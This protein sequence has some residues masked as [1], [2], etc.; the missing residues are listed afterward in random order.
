MTDANNHNELTAEALGRYLMEIVLQEIRALPDVWEKLSEN[1]QADVIDRVRESVREAV[2]G[3]VRLIST[4]GFDGVVCE[5]DA[6][7]IK[8]EIKASLIVSR[9]NGHEQLQQ[10]F[11]ARGEPCMV[12]LTN[13]EA[14]LGGMGLVQPEPDQRAMTLVGGDA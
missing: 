1:K 13:P 8:G 3:A 10:L 14:F 9:A 6:I 4:R 5:I 12:V 2:A 7:A 11:D